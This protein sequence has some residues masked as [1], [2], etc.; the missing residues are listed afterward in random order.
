MTFIMPI[1]NFLFGGALQ[2]FFTA[3]LTYKTNVAS[4]QEA[5]F[6]TA[7][8]VDAQNLQTIAT[9]E[10][11]NNALKVQVYGSTTYR[12]VTL[13]VGIPV[14]VHFGLIFIDTILASTFL[15]GR[16]VLGVPNPPGQYPVFEW[17]IISSFFLIHAVNIGASNVTQWL[18][19]K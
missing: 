15:C 7:A 2:S 6:V 1:L 14:A 9:T 13:I 10:I 16:A 18:G 8:T 4:S 3:Y 17:A 12:I 11:A 19:K 5:G